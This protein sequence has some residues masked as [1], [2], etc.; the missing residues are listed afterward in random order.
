MKTNIIFLVYM[1]SLVMFGCVSFS[2]NKTGQDIDHSYPVTGSIVETG[3][4]SYTKKSVIP[5]KKQ[6]LPQEGIPIIG[7]IETI[8]TPEEFFFPVDRQIDG[9]GMPVTNFLPAWRQVYLWEGSIA[10]AESRIA[11][12]AHCND[13]DAKGGKIFNLYGE[14]NSKTGVISLLHTLDNPDYIEIHGFVDAAKISRYPYYIGNLMTD[15]NTYQL[16]MLLEVEYALTNNTELSDDELRRKYPMIDDNI[17]A[18]AFYRTDQKF[19]IIDS[20]ETVV[21]EIQRDSYTLYD[22]LPEAERMNMKRDIGWF[23]TFR[24]ITQTLSRMSGWNMPLNSDM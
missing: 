22:T 21:A 15:T 20:S 16:Y 14:P 1:L 11:V 23:F 3:T 17:F 18:T 24:K 7:R 19:Q 8:G 13:K 10:S 4:L 9:N 2:Y 5:W 12:T 6:T